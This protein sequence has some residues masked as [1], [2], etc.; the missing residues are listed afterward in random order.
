MK[1]FSFKKTSA[2]FISTFAVFAMM[3]ASVYAAGV[4]IPKDYLP[5]NVPTIT[6]T[7][8]QRAE[9]F[10]TA[11]IVQLIGRVIAIALSLAAI[12]AVYF[13][14][15]NSFMLAAASGSNEMV[16]QYKKGLFWNVI[17]LVLIM[18]SYSLMKFI[19][20]LIIASANQEEVPAAGAGGAAP[21]S[22]VESSQPASNRSRLMEEARR[23]S[24]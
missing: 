24:S 22:A 4:V 5:N 16:E 1:I 7:D 12:M 21:A 17:G 2:L 19:V 14:V 8:E 20:W 11:A 18:V 15:N 9:N 13:I 10:N 3:S 6:G 23:V